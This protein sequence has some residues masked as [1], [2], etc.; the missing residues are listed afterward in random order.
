MQANKKFFNITSYIDIGTKV[1]KSQFGMSLTEV[2]AAAGVAS[3]VALGSAALIT[4]TRTIANQGDFQN[5]LDTRHNLN[6]QKLKNIA[7]VLEQ[8]RADRAIPGIVIG[9][10]PTLPTYGSVSIANNCFTGGRGAGCAA[11]N[12]AWTPLPDLMNGDGL[13]GLAGDRLIFFETRYQ[14][15][16]GADRCEKISVLLVTR[17]STEADCGNCGVSAER[18]GLRAKVRRTEVN[19]P[20]A[21]FADKRS[22]DFDCADAAGRILTRVNYKDLDTVCDAY[23]AGTSCAGVMPPTGYGGG[24]P[25]CYAAVNQ[26]CAKGVRTASASA[27]GCN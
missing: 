11:F 18:R 4:E 8:V 25:S 23:P 5:N 26:N 17:G 14:L 15:E 9:T 22:I 27:G 10:N 20:V 19:I 24:V 6:M 7:L 16:C 1:L 13:N 12:T 2:I 3:V 21:F